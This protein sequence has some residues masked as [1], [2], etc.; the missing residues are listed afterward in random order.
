MALADTGNP[1]PEWQYAYRY[2][3]DCMKAITIIRLG[4]KY[5]RPDQAIHFEVGS[6]EAGVS[7]L[8]YCD[9]PKAWLRYVAKVTDVNMFDPIF[10]DA[11][12]FA[13]A[14]KILEMASEQ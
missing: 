13:R 5:S 4:E 6:D 3:T 14:Y 9:Q 12:S 2:P 10:I 7:K 11:T 1:P 8:L